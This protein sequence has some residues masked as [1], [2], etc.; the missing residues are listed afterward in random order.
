MKLAT[1]EGPSARKRKT[2]R[3]NGVTGVH[4]HCLVPEAK[5]LAHAARRLRESPATQLIVQ[6]KFKQK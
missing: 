3:T 4:A 2:A 6:V 1:R 5:D